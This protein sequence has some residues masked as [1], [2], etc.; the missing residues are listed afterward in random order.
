[1]SPRAKPGELSPSMR[2]ALEAIEHQLATVGYPPTVRQ[3]SWLLGFRSN[4]AATTMLRQLE[5]CGFIARAPNEARAITVLR[6]SQSVAE[7]KAAP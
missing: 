6:S 5:L 4:N 7:R 1:M 2:R 3:L